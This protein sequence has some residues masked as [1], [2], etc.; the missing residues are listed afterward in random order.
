MT[1]R[2]IDLFSGPG[3]L[4]EG[5]T[6]LESGKAFRIAV[7]AEMET[8]AHATLTLRAFF[9]SA[10]LAGDKKALSSYYAFCNSNL[11]AHP[12]GSHSK[13]WAEATSE[14]RQLELGKPECNQQLD[15]I[16]EQQKLGADDTILIG[17]PPCQAY[18]SAG[19]SRN[20]GKVGYVPEEDKRHYLYREYL[21]V[22][23]KTVG[24]A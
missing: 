4:G 6:S 22:L 15:C 11:A 9:R 7:S 16:L 1:I 21:R 5:F 17:G 24:A 19:R 3:G 8:S 10:K 14:A 13:L 18:S 2:V 12:S 23:A 20:K